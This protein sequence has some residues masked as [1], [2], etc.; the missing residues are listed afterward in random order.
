MVVASSSPASSPKAVRH[1]GRFQLLRLLGKSERCMAWL[2]SDPRVGQEL[3]LV[4]P[5]TQ[6]AD[7]P[8]L[9]RWLDKARK[10]ARIEHPGLAHAVEVGQHERWPFITYDCGTGVTLAERLSHKGLAPQDLVPAMLPVLGGLAFAH[11]AGQ[12]HHDLQLT[13][14]LVADSGLCRLMGLAW[15]WIH[16]APVPTCSRGARPLSVTCWPSACCCTMRWSVRRHSTR[17]TSTR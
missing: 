17:P 11:E 6:L 10:A 12:V 8:A 3:V 5:R 9:Q 4:L 7:E 16:L 13:M 2:V 15:R 14:L 1:L